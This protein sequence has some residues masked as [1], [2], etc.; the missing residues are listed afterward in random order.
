MSERKLFGGTDGFR[1]L[2][3]PETPGP[4]RVNQETF[5]IA[6]Y[7]LLESQ[8]SDNREEQRQTLVTARDTR[9]SGP[10]LHDAVMAG[11]SMAGADVMN[12]EV[13]PTPTAQWVAQRHGADAAV[14]VT[15]S[16][17]EWYDNGWKGMPGGRKPTKD[18]LIQLTERY[19]A[20]VSSGLPLLPLFRRPLAR[21]DLAAEYSDA[22]VADIEATFGEKPLTDKLFVIDSA[23]GAVQN[24]TPRIFRTLG[25]TVVEYGNGHGRINEDS[26]A[27]RLMYPGQSGL[28]TFLLAHPEILQDERFAGALANDGDGDRVMGVGV[29]HTADG[30]ETVRLNGNHIMWAMAQGEPGIVGTDYTNSG[31]TSRLAAANIGFE[32]CANGDVNVTNRLREL[33]AAGKSWRRGGEF[34]GHLVDFEWLSSGDGVRMA[35]WYASHLVGRSMTLADAQEELPLWEE[36]LEAIKLPK[37][38]TGEAL[39]GHPMMVEAQAYAQD[40][41]GD[42]G[43]MHNRG[44]GTQPLYRLFVEATEAALA[45]QAI[46]HLLQASQRIAAA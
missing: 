4:W 44:S 22:V 40:I 30:F 32:F 17:N 5:G 14:S 20:H 12:L 9:E 27:E 37:R 33:Q 6:T 1:G 10:T 15:A 8:W 3:E 41:L 21:H 38:L 28:E 43:R 19:E 11:A 16:H 24:F 25:A 35:A 31:L 39:G 26:G 46:A 42:K 36:R 13:A 18:E 29:R 2:A 7:A 34:S 45:D 23:N